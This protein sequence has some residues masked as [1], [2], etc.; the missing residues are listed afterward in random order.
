MSIHDGRFIGDEGQ[1]GIGVGSI[2]GYS[3]FLEP[4]VHK[5]IKVHLFNDDRLNL[6]PYPDREL[7]DMQYLIALPHRDTNDN[8]EWDFYPDNTTEDGAFKEGNTSEYFPLNRTNDGAVIVSGDI[9]Y[10]KGV[11]PLAYDK[12]DL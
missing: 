8:Q 4:G 3:E 7:R 6:T 1:V 9:Q 12:E 11:V 5:N 2:I 10:R